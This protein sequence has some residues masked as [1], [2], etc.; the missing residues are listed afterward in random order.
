MH[1]AQ[2]TGPDAM[3]KRR[4]PAL[5]GLVSRQTDQTGSGRPG[6]R[7][8]P[9][10]PW[11]RPGLLRSLAGLGWTAGAALVF[12]LFLRISLEKLM[13]S[14]GANN[15][16]QA[17][18]MLH[19][20]LVLH[21]WIVGD[22]TF[23]T[24][25]LPIIAIL[26]FFLGLHADTMHVA[27]ALIYLIVAAFAVAIA[28]TDTR[29]LSRVIRASVVVAA[30]AAPTLVHSDLWIPLGIPDHTGTIAFLLASFLLVD[31]ATGRRLTAPLLCLILCAGQISDVTVRYVAVPAIAVVCL[32]QMLAARKLITWD[33][34]NLLAAG[35]S[36]PL[37]VG[38][39]AFMRVHLG[40]YLMVS[41]NTRIAP[42]SAWQT[43]ASVAWTSLR[44]V[45]GIDSGPHFGPVGLT[46]IFGYACLAAA[47]I[48]V[49]RVLWRWRTARRAEQALVIAMAANFMFY[50]LSTLVSPSSPHD[51]V[52]LL[53]CGGVLA[54]RALV[55]ERIASRLVAVP[56]T[57]LALVAALLPLSVAASQ[58]T[59]TSALSTVIAWLQANGL[60]YGLGGYWDSS[61]TALESANQVQVRAIDAHHTVNGNRISLYPW[62]TNTLWF[63]PA[64]HYAN[65]VILDLPK[66]NLLPTV[67]G[68]FGKPVRT[69]IIS[70]WEI[71]VYHENLL[72]YLAPPVLPPMS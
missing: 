63:D 13:E 15:A 20:N 57:C 25:E 2:P 59:Q 60:H 4:R 49:L 67:R 23:Y 6:E 65:F 29:G 35:L 44:E 18:D 66:L 41:P 24:F 26:E 31:R 46:V 68:V 55:P 1:A 17:W 51:L 37:A 19:G 30:L 50:M 72:T 27:E 70:T 43:N 8:L 45:Y 47:A 42:F 48:G 14:D 7:S 21:G 58:P 69:H 40:A 3:P 62:E 5:R 33:A 32:Y 56:A 10:R 36:V 54:A 16:L 64:K 11:P 9:S 71:F 52:A 22:V 38:I 61:E 12:A 34:A 53:P 28:V 39:P